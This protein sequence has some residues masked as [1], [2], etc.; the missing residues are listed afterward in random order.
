MDAAGL[1]GPEALRGRDVAA[2]S[3]LLGVEPGIAS[4]V[5]RL[6]DRA[7]RFTLDLECI[8]GWGVWV[9]SELD[10][11]YP[12]L[13]ARSSVERI[14]ASELTQ[15]AAEGL[16]VTRLAIEP[17]FAKRLLIDAANKRSQPLFD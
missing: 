6:L 2:I 8:G 12:R 17:V 4:R 16:V 13:A 7:G 15:A 11:G 14:D 1:K 9:V 5:A 3:S 10:A